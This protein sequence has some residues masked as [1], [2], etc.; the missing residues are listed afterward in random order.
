MMPYWAEK[1]GR[2]HMKARQLSKR[3]GTLYC[4]LQGDKVT[5][6]GPAALYSE[7]EIYIK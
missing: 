4:G 5:I 2:D 1:L 7:A 6:A 3:G